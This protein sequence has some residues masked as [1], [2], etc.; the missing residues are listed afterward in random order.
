MLLEKSA[1]ISARLPIAF[2]FP[3]HG[4]VRIPKLTGFAEGMAHSFSESILP[5]NFVIG[6]AYILPFGGLFQVFFRLQ[7]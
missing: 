3:G 7:A 2:S 4:L 5:Y 6:F 1:Y